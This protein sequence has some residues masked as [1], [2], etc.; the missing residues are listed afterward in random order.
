MKAAVVHDFG[1]APRYADFDES[2]PQPGETVL[3]V[4]AAGLHQLV[5]AR[6]SGQH[7]SSGTTL[8]QVAGADGVGRLPD[9][10]HAWFGPVPGP[11][12]T[13]AERVA[14][15]DG[16]WLV[17]PDGAD[18]VR[19]AGQVN[20]A[21]SSWLALRLRA[22]L[23][24]GQT[25]AVLGATGASGRLAVQIAKTLG[26]GRVVAIGR[27]PAALEQLTEIGADRIVRLSDEGELL[28]DLG[29]DEIDVIVDYLWSRPAVNLLTAAL[30]DREDPSRPLTLVQV[31]SMAGAEA[32]I[33]A[34]ALRSR[35]LRVVGSGIGSIPMPEVMTEMPKIIAAV[36][37]DTFDAPIRAVAL[38][39]VESAW[40][41]ETGPGMRI[42]LVP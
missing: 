9:G 22:G 6:A 5:R 18:S 36:A 3:A 38:D 40:T 25:V 30:A 10:R 32:A 26:A 2:A 37:A 28:E 27:N 39:E 23:Q 12:G 4:V 1:L 19:V 41:A 29:P 8:P 21:M 33:P 13:M 7:Y 34:A 35:N 17:L 15:R 11:W 20:T 16:S 31:G 42:V 14:V 24:P